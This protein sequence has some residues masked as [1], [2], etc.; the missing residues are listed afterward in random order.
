MKPKVYQCTKCHNLSG[1]WLRPADP[2]VCLRCKTVGSPRAVGNIKPQ[3]GYGNYRVKTNRLAEELAVNL[4]TDATGGFVRE[5]GNDMFYIR[6]VT[7]YG[8]LYQR[9]RSRSLKEKRNE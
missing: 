3:G 1:V 6:W 7:M 5:V 8:R 2:Y 9:K 4:E